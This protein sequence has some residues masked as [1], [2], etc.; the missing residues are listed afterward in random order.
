MSLNTSRFRLIDV[1]LLSSK[2]SQSQ[3]FY[4]EVQCQNQVESFREQE[5]HFHFLLERHQNIFL[6]LNK[7]RFTRLRQKHKGDST[8]S[9]KLLISTSMLEKRETLL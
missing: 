5:L 2:F 8:F 7:K 6:P 1:I 3:R 4:G 9:F